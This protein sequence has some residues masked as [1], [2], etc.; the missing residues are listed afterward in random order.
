MT[1]PPTE[2]LRG[3]ALSEKSGAPFTTSAAEAEWLS[4][5]F[6]PVIVSG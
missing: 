5:P 6:V 4:V 1:L 3:V 2:R